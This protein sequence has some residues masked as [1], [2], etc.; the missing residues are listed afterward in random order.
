MTITT[1][2]AAWTFLQ[3]IRKKVISFMS[4]ELSFG[5]LI[6]CSVQFHLPNHKKDFRIKRIAAPPGV[7]HY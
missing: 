7:Q 4:S 6:L 3:L 5:K 2:Q 1:K